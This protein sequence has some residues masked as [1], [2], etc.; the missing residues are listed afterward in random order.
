VLAGDFAYISTAVLCL[1]SMAE[2]NSNNVGP[3]DE[4]H[5][6]EDGDV[7][8]ED[9]DRS[10]SS[11]D[12]TEEEVE[13]EDPLT[14]PTRKRKV[15]S[16][17]WEC[18]GMKVDGGSKCCVVLPNGLICGKLFKITT[19]NTSNIFFLVCCQVKLPRSW[20]HF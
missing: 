19:R 14:A 8:N 4:V 16:P 12:E 5:I 6:V 7:E 3:G 9:D 13:V 17:I 11:D 15:P 20:L 10:S 1:H 2:V 18:G